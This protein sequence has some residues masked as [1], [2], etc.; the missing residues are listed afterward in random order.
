M[1]EV[2]EVA[3]SDPTIISGVPVN[4]VASPVTAPVNAPTNE[5]AVIVPLELILPEAVTFPTLSKNKP[6]V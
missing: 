2:I 5:F 1:D 4:P 6:F 3:V